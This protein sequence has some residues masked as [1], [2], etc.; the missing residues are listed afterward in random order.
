MQNPPP[1]PPPGEGPGPEQPRGDFGQQPGY[2]PPPA[3]GGG[4]EPPSTPGGGY[5]QQPPPPTGGGYQPPPPPPAGGYEP[6][7]GG[8]Q[9]GGSY[10]QPQGSGYQ[11]PPS[12]Q[13]AN[14]QGQPTTSGIDSKTGC[15]IAYVLQWLTGLIM[16]FVGKDNPNVR[17]HGAQS[18]IFFGGITV[19][20]IGLSI[21]GSIVSAA[22]NSGI[23]AIF[24]LIELLLGLF[25]FIMWIVCI[26][27]AIQS[28]GERWPIPLVGGFVTP[29]AERMAGS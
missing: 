4:Y 17:Y 15:I 14:Y 12:Y 23:G 13:P 26:V 27:K 9:P 18:L 5:G 29:Y 6:P 7:T 11:Q 19:I 22:T 20:N 10:Q 16:Y 28:H 25:G 1:G 24:G 8:Y 21:L 2:Q 3:P